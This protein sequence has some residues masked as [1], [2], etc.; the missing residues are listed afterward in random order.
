MRAVVAVAALSAAFASSGCLLDATVQY[1][2]VEQEQKHFATSGR[3]EVTLKTFDGSIEVR[4]WDKNDVDVT[5]EKRGPSKESLD[6]LEITST[7]D[8]NRIAVEVRSKRH[9]MGG[10][11]LG[12]SPNARLIVSLPAS[13]DL[14][15]HSGDGSIDVERVTGHVDLSSGDGSIRARGLSG[16]V[17][18]H[19]GDGR[20]TLDGTF[21]SLKASSGDGS[22]HIRADS[23]SRPA[24]DWLITTGDGSITLEIPD[25]FDGNLDAH[26]GDGRV[27]IEDV[28]VSNVSGEIHRNSLKGQLGS[29]G[30]IVKLRTGDGSITVKRS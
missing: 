12:M 26:T 18:V 2:V 28:T 8:G 27:R 6:D 24:G 23:G 7:Q 22:V 29:G 1:K 16:D 10:W 15:A 19:T 20:V 4:P 3:P 30:R 14:V 5:I 17:N 13:S 21:A 9:R 11:H 25:G